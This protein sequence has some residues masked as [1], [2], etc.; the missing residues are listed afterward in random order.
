[1]EVTMKINPQ[2]Q[3]SNSLFKERAGITLI[4]RQ[5]SF[6]LFRLLQLGFNVCALK[7]CWNVCVSNTFIIQ[8]GL[9]KPRQ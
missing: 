7:A 3:A 2:V 1:M 4:L 9:T 6:T 8:E 5:E